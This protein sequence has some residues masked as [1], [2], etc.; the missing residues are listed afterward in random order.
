MPLAVY[1]LGVA[2]FAQGTSELMLAGLLPELSADLGVSVPDAGLL[3]SGFAIGMLVGGPALAVLTLRWP[4]RTA[5]LSFM[6]AFAAMH[7]V[8]G[9]TSS[10]E[11]LLATR[12]AGAFVYA[13]FW[14]VAAV[15]AINLVPAGARGRALSVVVGG[16]TMAILIGL[17]AG[18]LMG[19][20]LSWRAT[21]WAVAA[22]SALAAAGVLAT[23]PNTRQQGGEPSVRAEVRAL[24]RPQVWLAVATTAV[25]TAALIVV[26]T[27]LG[28]LV[29][30]TTGLAPVWVAGVLALYGLGSLIG[31]TLGGRVAD[32]RPFA[33][34]FAG[35]SG[36]TLVSAGIALGAAA[37]WA[38]VP[39]AFLLGAFGFA[40]NPA[41]NAR[42]FTLAAGAPTLA[43]SVNVSAFNLGITAGPWLGGLALE[44]GLG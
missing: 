38:V 19:Q 8:G 26:F 42:V 24:A 7:V 40:A 43:A 21:F 4:P 3:I 34:L 17:P 18:T 28:A 11:V 16:L 25:S 35:L 2:I 9:L 12:V 39:L 27:Y 23:V 15:T 36:V 1:I 13:G 41:L 29:V 14:A 6:A 37:A 30:D 32:A 31:V 20:S 5:L 44:A 33:L 22:L 10:Y